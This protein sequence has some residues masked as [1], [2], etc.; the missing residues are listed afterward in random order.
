[1]AVAPIKSRFISISSYNKGSLSSLLLTSNDIFIY[2]LLN[3]L[4]SSSLNILYAIIN[5]LKPLF[6][7]VFKFLFVSIKISESFKFDFNN[8]SII[9]SAPFEYKI[10]LFSGV[11][12]ITLIL[13][14]S[15]EYS[16]ILRI[17]YKYVLLSISIS[18]SLSIVL[19]LNIY[20]T[21]LAKYIN[22]F[23]SGLEL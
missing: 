16:K 22:A 6:A 9:E 15:L 17:L 18:I 7:N 4:Y 2:F 3:S 11:R 10:I 20:P 23:S 14:L 19:F 12:T 13:F 21:L 5:V 1:M 8:F